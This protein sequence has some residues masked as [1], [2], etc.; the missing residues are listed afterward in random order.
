MH[1]SA[2]YSVFSSLS[3]LLFAAGSPMLARS[4]FPL[5]LVFGQNPYKK[6]VSFNNLEGTGGQDRS[7]L[8]AAAM[9]IANR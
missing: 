9:P 4:S 3:L 5:S 2:R 7:V 6:Y 8:V 1:E